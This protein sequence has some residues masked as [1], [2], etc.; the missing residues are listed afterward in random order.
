MTMTFHI[1]GETLEF[2]LRPLGNQ[3]LVLETIRTDEH[4]VDNPTYAVR[5][6]KTGQELFFKIDK[7]T[8]EPYLVPGVC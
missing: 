6:T 7:Q 8:N 5:N 4:G 2:D 1:P 3:G